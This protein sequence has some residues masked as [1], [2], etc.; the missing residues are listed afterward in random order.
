MRNGERERKRQRGIEEDDDS[1][2]WS[3]T[4]NKSRERFLEKEKQI[5]FD[6]YLVLRIYAMILKTI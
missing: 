6:Y 1:I 5:R 3:V 4:V 2:R